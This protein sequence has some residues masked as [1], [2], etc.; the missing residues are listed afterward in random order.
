MNLDKK[1]PL[2]SIIVPFYNHNKFIKQTLDSFLEDTYPNKEIIIIN[3]G[4][5]EL[6][7][8]NIINWIDL[9]SKHIKINYIKRKNE[10]VTKT[11]NQLI[12]MSN[13]EYI[14]PCSSDDY[15][16][17]NTIQS[18]IDLL[19]GNKNKEIIIGDCIIVDNDN[20]LL[21]KSNLFECRNHKLE[22]YMTDFGLATMIIKKW[23]MAGPSWLAKKSLFDKIGLFDENLIVEDWDFMLRVVSQNLAIFYPDKPVSAY[24]LHG[25]NTINNPEKQIRMWEDLYRTAK[26]HI[27]S[28]NNLYFKYLMWN[29]SKKNLKKLNELR[30]MN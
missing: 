19:S 10:G 9:H 1:V 5:T 6:Q 11:I 21:F 16:I 25:N 13:G 7:D 23:S 28:F 18:R 27:K 14:L 2:V 8:D 17:N 22:E 12:S 26:K 29:N 24:R 20:K 15:F 3:D 4:S 30:K